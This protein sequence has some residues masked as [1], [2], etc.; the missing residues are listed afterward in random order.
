[1]SLANVFFKNL[2]PLART[3]TRA[4]DSAGYD[5]FPAEAGNILPGE[6]REIRLGFA[7]SFDRGYA[8]V[9][10]DRGSTGSRGL[11]HLAGVIDADFRGEWKV[12]IVN[13]GTEPYPY[14]P[15]KAIAQV[16][17]LKV[18]E[19]DFLPVD[20]LDPTLRGEGMKGSSGH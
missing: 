19:P 18:E 6:R 4:F 17:F 5:V 15:E 10:D 20:A 13:L 2:H 1:M 12:L 8:A 3:P 16:L 14:T 11:T 9:I 7:T